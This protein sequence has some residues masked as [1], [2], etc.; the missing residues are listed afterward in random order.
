MK[1]LKV[2]KHRPKQ[3]ESWQIL[4]VVGET[5]SQLEDRTRQSIKTGFRFDKFRYEFKDYPIVKISDNKANII[6]EGSKSDV[7]KIALDAINESESKEV[8]TPNGLIF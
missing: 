3:I 4:A 6:K 8:R 2:V 1:Y 7:K 5:K